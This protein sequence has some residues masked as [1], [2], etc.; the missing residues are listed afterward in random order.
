M[1]HAERGQSLKEE[2]TEGETD[3]ILDRRGFL[4]STV[5]KI[6]MLGELDE[7]LRGKCEDRWEKRR[8]PE[9][10]LDQERT[11]DEG[12]IG[13][14]AEDASGPP[15][16][17]NAIVGGHGEAGLFLT[18]FLSPFLLALLALPSD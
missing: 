9:I 3:A 10:Y 16:P 11:G 2:E 15:K 13:N 1:V 6:G 4:T 5:G 7:S 18:G 14:K 17:E 8:E 12:D